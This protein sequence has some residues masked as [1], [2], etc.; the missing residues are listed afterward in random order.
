M[1]PFRLALLSLVSATALLAADA[2]GWETLFNGTS[3]AKWRGYKQSDFPTKGW[4]VEDGALKVQG[5]GGDL[6]T[7][8]QYGSFELLWEWKVSPGA[9]SGLIYH[10]SEE[11][12][13]SYETGPEYQILDDAKHG[14]GK[15]PKTS[16][17]ALYALI[18]PNANK[19]LKPVGEWNKSR[20]VI[21]GAHV[22]HWLN[23]K[24]IVQ[25]DLGSPELKAL[26]AQSK[27]KDM[28]KFAQVTSGH[29]CLQDHGDAVWYRNI[30]VK[31]LEVK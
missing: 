9:N 12:G 22:Q 2:V 17:G 14:D 20:L 1:K 27:F 16:A 6:V 23:G 15:N 5:G 21:Y 30:R 28:P 24:L 4:V 29:I 25:Y 18:A 19:Q 13:A 11:F 26:I 7:R 10:V 3:T 31:R 8:D